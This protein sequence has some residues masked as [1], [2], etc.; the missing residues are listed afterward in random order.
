MKLSHPRSI[1]T[2]DPISLPLHMR[3]TARNLVV[4]H[5]V[6]TLKHRQSQQRSVFLSTLASIVVVRLFGLGVGACD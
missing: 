1:S 5:L 4:A 2:A 3:T 6:G